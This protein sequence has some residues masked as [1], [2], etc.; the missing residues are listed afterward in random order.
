MTFSLAD[1]GSVFSTRPRGAALRAEA[2][3]STEDG[4]ELRISFAG[5][6]SVSYSFAD[7]FLG[8]LLVGEQA[9]ASLEEVPPSLHRV[10][11]GALR[12]RGLQIKSRDLFPPVSA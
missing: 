1:H 9:R 5:V 7:E 6:K 11:L 2:L 12:R 10:I 8:P 3:A 4:E